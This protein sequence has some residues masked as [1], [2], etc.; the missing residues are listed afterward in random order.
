MFLSTFL[1]KVD[2]IK[3]L[4]HELVVSTSTCRARTFFKTFL[5]DLENAERRKVKGKQRRSAMVQ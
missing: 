1:N 2:L 4:L 3:P 5:H